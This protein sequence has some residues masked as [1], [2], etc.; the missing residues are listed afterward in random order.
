MLCVFMVLFIYC[1]LTDA[2]QKMSFMAWHLIVSLLGEE[3]IVIGLFL[4]VCYYIH[5]GSVCR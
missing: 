5:T 4:S 1:V 2:V 3:D